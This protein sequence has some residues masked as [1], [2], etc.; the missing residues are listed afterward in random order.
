M[1]VASS[2]VPPISYKHF[3]RSLKGMNPSVS[4]EDLDDYI[5]FNE[6]YGI[7]PMIVISSL[8][9]RQCGYK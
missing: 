5:K 7:H 6:T 2:D 9:I 8:I 1:E 4:K 3:R